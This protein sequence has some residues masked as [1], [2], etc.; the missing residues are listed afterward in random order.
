MK[1]YSVTQVLNPFAD[2]SGIPEWKLEAAKVRGKKVHAACGSYA[3]G[4]WVA[5]LLEEYQGYYESFLGWFDN[6]V[7]TV[8]FV[9]LRLVC[10]M[11]HFTGRIDLAVRLIDQKDMVIDLKTP[12]AESPTWKGQLAA[13][14]HLANTQE[15]G[16]YDGCMSLQLSP[17]GRPAKAI[18]YQ[19]SD[20]DFA[21]FLSALNAYRYFKI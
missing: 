18:V 17:H 20:N 6:F 1:P 12:L 21:A 5:P 4:V 15:G 9:E 11:Y 8:F 2:F 16:N 10:D 14:L 19:Y 3:L 7:D 13:Y